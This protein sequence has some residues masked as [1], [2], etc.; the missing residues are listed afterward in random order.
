[1]RTT[2][3]TTDLCDADGR[4]SMRLEHQHRLQPLNHQL[5]TDDDERCDPQRRQNDG[6]SSDRVH[7]TRAQRVADRV[8]SATRR[9]I[10]C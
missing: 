2:L 5:R 7:V 3:S 1:M 4:V 6:G 10:L 9:T 8:V